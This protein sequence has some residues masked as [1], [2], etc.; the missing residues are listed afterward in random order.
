MY[1]VYV[2][3]VFRKV[4]YGRKKEEEINNNLLTVA[5]WLR[6]RWQHI[7]DSSTTKNTLNAGRKNGLFFKII[8]FVLGKIIPIMSFYEI[9]Y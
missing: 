6:Q 7:N 9:W 4:P 2:K 8:R 3:F 5:L 1:A